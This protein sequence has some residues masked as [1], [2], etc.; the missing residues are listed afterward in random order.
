LSL[1]CR[2]AL[3][4]AISDTKAIY[5]YGLDIVTQQQHRRYY[6]DASGMPLWGGTTPDPYRFGW[7]TWDAKTDRLP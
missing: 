4:D 6:G 1:A 5:L 2:L 3:A 7:G